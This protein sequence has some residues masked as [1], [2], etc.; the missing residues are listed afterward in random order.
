MCGYSDI[1]P[2]SCFLC[3][4]HPFVQRERLAELGK[5]YERV[6]VTVE[7]FGK[8]LRLAALRL[9][10]PRTRQVLSIG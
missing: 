6:T 8:A 10:T 1:F 3:T 5:L 4:Q 2:H 7:D 9:H